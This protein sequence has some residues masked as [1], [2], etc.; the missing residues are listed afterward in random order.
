MRTGA[1]KCGRNK[2]ALRECC[3]G[4]Q[5]ESRVAGDCIVSLRGKGKYGRGLI[6]LADMFT[7]AEEQSRGKKIAFESAAVNLKKDKQHLFQQNT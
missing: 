2:E 7:E 5:W 6:P 3:E 1:K 4:R